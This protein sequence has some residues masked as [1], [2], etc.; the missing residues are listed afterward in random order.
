[1]FRNEIRLD[2]LSDVNEFVRIVT[3]IEGKVTVEDG[4]GHCV[5]AKSLL[6]MMYASGEFTHKYAVSEKDISVAILKFLI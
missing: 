4:E 2:T 1:M 5:D 6:G 3:T